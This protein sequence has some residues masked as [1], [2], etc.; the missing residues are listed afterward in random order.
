MNNQF[1]FDI[2]NN[3]NNYFIECCKILKVN[4]SHNES[5]LKKAFH[6]MVLKTHPDK[7][8]DPKEFIKVKESYLFLNSLI[9]KKAKKSILNNFFPHIKNSDIVYNN[10]DFGRSKNII[11]NLE[12]EMLEAYYGSQKV[13][14][15]IR[16]RICL[17][18]S[19]KSLL[20]NITSNCPECQGKKYS[21]QAKD[22]KIII[23][24][25]TY[26]GCKVVFKEEGDE[27]IGVKPGDFIFDIIVKKDNIYSRKGAD[28]Y[29]Q[30]I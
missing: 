11:C 15:L 7:G 19:K 26:T 12:I 30:K 4:L 21:P 1:E 25:G 5:E 29:L 22:V 16:N 20:G 3:F 18:C 10:S 14:R 9:H 17:T 27:Y 24:P 2:N 28:L 13:K 6:E 23:K 8:G